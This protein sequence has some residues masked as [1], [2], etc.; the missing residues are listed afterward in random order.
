[1]D[2]MSI[3]QRSGIQ[4]RRLRYVVFHL[5]LPGI[6]RAAIG[7]GS[8]RHFTAF[9]AFGLAF[10]ATLLDTGLSRQFACEILAALARSLSRQ[11]PVDQIPLYQ[12]FAS[13]GDVHIDVADRKY[14]RVRGRDALNRALPAAWV[15]LEAGA[16][17]WPDDCRPKVLIMID[18]TSL[19][20]AMTAQ[21]N[22]RK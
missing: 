6:D 16:P 8:V 4:P 1:M 2:L 13:R 10:S 19:R 15:P 9:E 22:I 20:D 18:L 21:E 12:A 7:K 11:Q 5:L 14:A 17:G 3:S